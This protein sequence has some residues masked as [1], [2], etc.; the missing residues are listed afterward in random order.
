[1][2]ISDLRFFEAVARL[3]GMSRAS[4]ELNTV[5]SN[6]TSRVKQLEAELGT[7]LFVR[8]RRGVTL[9]EAGRRLLPFA[10][11]ARLLLDAA[12]QAARDDG[13]PSGTLTI[14]SLET[15]AARR[16]PP[17]LATFGQRFP[18]VDL[19]LRTATNARLLDDVRAGRL[20]GAFVCGPVRE[21]ELVAE[22]VYREQLVIV[23]APSVSSWR[24]L[25]RHGELRIVVKPP[26]CSYRS[27]LETIL[28][29]ERI[30][31]RRVEFGTLEAVLGCVEA[32]LGTTL[33]PV[34]IVDA[35][36]RQGKFATHAIASNEAEAE[37]LFVRH[38]DAYRSSALGALLKLVL[39]SDARSCD[40]MTTV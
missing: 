12:K 40:E 2:D 34:S 4:S 14:G 17:I 31:A 23:T 18:D 24:H 9:T 27:R 30:T 36:V 26:G 28:E 29:R 35:G 37:T 11:R 5:Q 13:S 19:V 39:P 1:M 32:G 38:V 21:G 15:T 22:T 8:G 3:G 20:E 25:V 7:K 10:V 33:L 16:L 6:V